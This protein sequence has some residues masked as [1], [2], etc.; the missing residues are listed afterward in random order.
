MLYQKYSLQLKNKYNIC[1]KRFILLFFISAK[2]NAI[3]F[4]IIIIVIVST[5]TTTSTILLFTTTIVVILSTPKLYNCHRHFIAAAVL[6]SFWLQQLSNR[7]NDLILIHSSSINIIIVLTF[8]YIIITAHASS[9]SLLDQHSHRYLAPSLSSSSF[10]H[11]TQT[12]T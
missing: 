4:I 2:L 6:L 7:S 9:P 10:I 8:I 5:T 3:C 1:R 11:L 12:L